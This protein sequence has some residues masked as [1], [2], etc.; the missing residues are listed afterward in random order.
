MVWILVF[1]YWLVVPIVL[2]WNSYNKQLL[3]RNW[4]KFAWLTSFVCK[5]LILKIYLWL[6]LTYFHC[7][8]LLT[9]FFAYSELQQIKVSV[10]WLC[11][12]CVCSKSEYVIYKL[13]EMGKVSEKD[14]MQICAQFD[15]LDSG[16]CGKITL[17]DLMSRHWYPSS[18]LSFSSLYIKASK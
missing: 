4:R 1:S 2:A 7:L 5:V 15:R 17:A 6:G 9:Y 12:L 13:K 18:F 8:E 16:N 3:F 11:W 10:G 14:V